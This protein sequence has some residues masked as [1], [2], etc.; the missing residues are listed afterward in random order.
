MAKGI[1][2]YLQ[3][4]IISSL[5]ERNKN[6]E[7]VGAMANREISRL[8][9]MYAEALK[10]TKLTEAE[11]MFIV[12]ILNS[13]IMDERSARMLWAEAEDACRLDSTHEKWDVDA[14]A[15]VEKLRGF[16]LLQLMA[17]VD[18]SDRFWTT[19]D[20]ER[21]QDFSASIKKFFDIK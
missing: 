16:N 20:T 9:S 5:Q 15:I 14:K 2:V 8:Y 11:A 18:A 12:D 3:E 13:A 21:N 6:S 7:P 10:E 17:I 1:N 4:D 19:D